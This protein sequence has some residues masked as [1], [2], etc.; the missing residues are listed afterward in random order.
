MKDTHYQQSF[1][2]LKNY[3]EQIRQIVQGRMK[4]AVLDMVYQTL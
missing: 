3:G 4:T 1:Q 2:S